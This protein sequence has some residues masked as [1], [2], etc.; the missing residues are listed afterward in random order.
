MHSYETIKIFFRIVTCRLFHMDW[1]KKLLNEYIHLAFFS[2]LLSFFLYCL[3]LCLLLFC[4]Q[5]IVSNNDK[6][7]E[8]VRWPRIRWRA[9][10]HALVVVVF[11]SET[12]D[13]KNGTHTVHDDEREQEQEKKIYVFSRFSF[14]PQ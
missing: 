13:A 9:W 10:V 11:V 12:N 14:S 1:M 2:F 7:R 3:R 6:I 5:R 4:Q 8:W